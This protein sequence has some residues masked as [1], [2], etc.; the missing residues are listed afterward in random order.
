MLTANVNCYFVMYLKR[1]EISGFKSFA[2]KSTLEF[3]KGVSAVVGPNGSGKSNIADAARWVMGEQGMK[4]L[5]SKKSEDLIY[6]GSSQKSAAGKAQVSLYFDNSDRVFP[7]DFGEI[8][9]TR[10]IFRNGESEYFINDASCRLKDILELIAKAKLGLRGYTIINQGMGDFIL[11]ASPSQRREI[12]EDALGLKEFQ[13]KKIEAKNKLELTKTNLKQAGGLIAEIGPHLKFLKRQA[14]KIQQKEI[15]E[16]NLLESEQK[17]FKARLAALGKE[18]DGIL[19]SKE[20]V[21][22]IIAEESGVMLTLKDEISKDEEQLESFFDQESILEKELEEIILKKSS[23]EREL[24]KIEGILAYR[25]E[26]PKDI[27]EAVDLSYLNN[28]L[29]IIHQKVKEAVLTASVEEMKEKLKLILADFD[30]VLEEIKSGKIKKDISGQEKPKE[31]EIIQ[32]PLFIEK[33]KLIGL[34]NDLENQ[35]KSARERTKELN[36]FYRAQ[37]DK[38]YFAKKELYERESH[39]GKLK[40]QSQN[41]NFRLDRILADMELVKQEAKFIENAC[42][43]AIESAALPSS[44]ELDALKNEIEKVRMRLEM[45][46]NID[47]EIQ[48]EFEETQKRYDFLNREMEDL[49]KA[50]VSLNDVVADLEGKIETIFNES[51]MKINDEFNRYFNMLFEGGK[52]HLVKISEKRIEKSEEIMEEGG[53]SELEKETE[54][55]GIDIKVDLPRKKVKD[56]HM[57]SGGERALTSIALIFAL[58]SCS[59]PPFLMLDEIDA[60]LD[61]SNALRFGRILEELRAKTQFVVITHNRETMKQADVL[62]GVTMGDDGVS[63]LFS[64]KLEEAAQAQVKS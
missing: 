37:K 51:F 64:L 62:Y 25:Q 27:Y 36:N 6:N 40:E 17:Y 5:R 43:A 4:A 26:L 53:E 56:I 48:K 7:M 41:F 52:A 10:K 46:E 30:K 39:Y 50:I 57:L 58:V 31:K 38:L 24:G 61:E 3:K 54:G 44:Y 21:D 32:E 13:L 8:G 34:L 22:R 49:D 35:I 47:P 11:S 2:N 1:L 23:L 16:K 28:V 55:G 12:F 60:P 14:E 9:I 18:K 20:D 63:K 29:R 19:K 45:T 33:E 59:P 15:L 42:D